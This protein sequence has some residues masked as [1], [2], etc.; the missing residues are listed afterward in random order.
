MADHHRHQ[1][2]EW[3]DERHCRK[4]PLERIHAKAPPQG[5]AKQ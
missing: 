4:I 5:A 1:R 3:L 2:I